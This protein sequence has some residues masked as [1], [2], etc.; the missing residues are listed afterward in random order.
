MKIVLF[1]ILG[2]MLTIPSFSSE[3]TV[4]I[5]LVHPID[6]TATGN[7]GGH[8]SP[9]HPKACPIQLFA[10]WDEEALQ[11]VGIGDSDVVSFTIC[12]SDDEVVLYG[13]LSQTISSIDISS[14]IMG[15]YYIEITFNGVNYIGEF[16]I[17]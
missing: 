5:P 8:K 1:L 11:V 3:V 15:T 6:D 2:I 16:E 17:E 7:V 14:L 12:D 13:N 10:N 9:V 4:P